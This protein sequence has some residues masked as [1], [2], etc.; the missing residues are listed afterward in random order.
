MS[1]PNPEN[2]RISL[3]ALGRLRALRDQELRA[4][5]QIASGDSYPDFFVE[6]SGPPWHERWPEVISG[7]AFGD[8]A[9]RVRALSQLRVVDAYLR[10]RGE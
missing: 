1:T 4:A 5:S 6:G 3:T 2:P 10:L 7:E 8:P 9:I